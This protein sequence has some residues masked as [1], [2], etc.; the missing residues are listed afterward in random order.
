MSRV[1]SLMVPFLKESVPS[2]LSTFLPIGVCISGYRYR[3]F[4]IQSGYVVGDATTIATNR[5]MQITQSIEFF[6]LIAPITTPIIPNS[7]R[8]PWFVPRNRNNRH[9]L[10]CCRGSRSN[11]CFSPTSPRLTK[12]LPEW[13]PNVIFR[14]GM[15]NPITANRGR[16]LPSSSLLGLETS[17][18]SRVIGT[19]VRKK[20][21]IKKIRMK[22]HYVCRSFGSKPGLG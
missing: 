14:G 10:K 9:I 5:F 22:T 6:D 21:Q 4:G 20:N 8:L 7:T 15:V 3:A 19:I 16:S 11:P 2:Q 13:A 1:F 18:Q 17:L 12:R